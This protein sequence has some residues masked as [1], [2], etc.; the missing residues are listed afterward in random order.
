M[1]AVQVACLIDGHYALVDFFVGSPASGE[2]PFR[3]QADWVARR[4]AGAVSE[5]SMTAVREMI[6]Q[7]IMSGETF[8]E[9][10]REQ[11]ARF[12]EPDPA[13]PSVEVRVVLF[14]YGTTTDERPFWLFIS[15][16]PE[17][18]KDFLLAISARSTI[19]YSE[20]GRIL[21]YGFDR[22]VPVV[23][24]GEMANSSFGLSQNL[25]DWLQSVIEQARGDFLESDGGSGSRI[26]LRKAARAARAS[27]ANTVALSVVCNADRY[28]EVWVGEPG[29][30]AN[31]IGEQ[32]AWLQRE[33]FTTVSK[34]ALGALQ[35]LAA[36]RAE[37]VRLTDLILT[38]LS[39]P[40][41]ETSEAPDQQ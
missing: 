29:E 36:S 19:E 28:E 38:T 32:A 20:Y 5:V 11:R 7:S 6:D 30:G 33:R 17:K 1:Q 34:D 15:V 26:A 24:A 39:V 22:F 35:A 18:F 12:L 37:S 13:W 31:P 25:E 9:L 2:H 21:R 16:T 4:W 27:S 10:L 23:E 3:Q 40:V 8:Y 41:A 14:D